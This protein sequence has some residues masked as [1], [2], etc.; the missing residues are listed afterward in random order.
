MPLFER[1]WYG[2]EKGIR[3]FRGQGRPKM[4]FLHNIFQNVAQFRFND[5]QLA[6][7][8]GIHR[9]FTDIYPNDINPLTGDDRGRG[10]ADIAQPEYGNCL[11]VHS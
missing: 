8:D 5:M 3:R 9:M 1:S 11:N 6:R 10:K 4:A 2:D 7:I